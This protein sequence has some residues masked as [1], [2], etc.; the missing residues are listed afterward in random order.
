M[1]LK[2]TMTFVILVFLSGL[3]FYVKYNCP[4]NEGFENLT[5]PKCPDLIVQKGSRYYLYNTNLAEI[6]GVN[7]IVFDNLDDYTQFIKWQ[8]SVGIKCPVLYLQYTYDAQGEKV[9]KIRPSV[10]EPQY[11]LPSTLP[12]K[13]GDQVQKVSLLVDATRNDNPY[14]T[15]SYPS[16]DQENQ[17]IGKYTPLDEM[18]NYEEN[19]LASDNAIN[20]NWDPVLAQKH[21]DEGYYKGSEVNIFIP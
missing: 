13:K 16:Y 2:V 9:Y 11:G 20:T 19:D 17:D 7:P 4:K 15:N 8:R 5:K 1:D 21:I 12:L 10:T 18:N 3:Y 14:N 6:P